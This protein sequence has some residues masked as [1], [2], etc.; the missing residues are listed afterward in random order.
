MG[1]PWASYHRSKREW[2]VLWLGLIP[3][4]AALRPVF[5]AGVFA[6]PV[7]RVVGLAYLVRL[8][9]VSVRFSY[10]ACPRCGKPFLRRAL[11]MGGLNDLLPGR[12]C[13]HFGLDQDSEDWLD[14]S[15]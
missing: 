12:R 3:V 13:K 7:A 1:S 6:N 2:I 4:V 8:T 15:G 14:V 11:R 5:G 9:W 10:W